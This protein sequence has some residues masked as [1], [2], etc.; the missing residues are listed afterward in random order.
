MHYLQLCIWPDYTYT[1]WQE[2]KDELESKKAAWQSTESQHMYV[3][4]EIHVFI[5]CNIVNKYIYI[6]EDK[7]PTY[8]ELD[9]VDGFGCIASEF[10]APPLDG[11]VHS[12]D[13]YYDQAIEHAQ[14][15]IDANCPTEPCSLDD[16]TC[17]P[18]DIICGG[19]ITFDYDPVLFYPKVISLAYG[20]FIADA[21]IAYFM[22][23][24]SV[25]EN[26][27]KF[28][29]KSVS[30]GSDG[31]SLVSTNLRSISFLCLACSLAIFSALISSML[32]S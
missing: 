28:G 19:S 3:I 1:D 8:V 13:Y 31:L 30:V 5:G 32:R 11:K 2:A 12:I 14:R 29:I 23:C 7:Y 6:I 16:F 25:F 22:D 15:G 10:T 4:K 21:G 18:A 20:P 9:D 27:L 26:S 17:D 24:L